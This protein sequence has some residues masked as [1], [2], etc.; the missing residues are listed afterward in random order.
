MEYANERDVALT[1]AGRRRKLTEERVFLKRLEE[2]TTLRDAIRYSSQP[3]HSLNLGDEALYTLAV[4]RAARATIVEEEK[5]VAD[6][7]TEEELQLQAMRDEAEAVAR[8]RELAEKQVDLIL[9]RMKSQGLSAHRIP[10][11]VRLPQTHQP[12]PLLP[13]PS[14]DTSDLES[15]Y[16]DF[17]SY[18]DV[19]SCPR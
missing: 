2:S 17:E 14:S 19:P 9:N 3:E 13:R 5:L 18:Y 4:A 8:K 7:I 6:R 16:S 11:P 1:R 15:N 12:W 10:P